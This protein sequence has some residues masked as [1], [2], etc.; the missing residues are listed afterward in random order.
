MF[1][2]IEFTKVETESTVLEF[3][4]QSEETKVN[5]FD[6]DVVSV[7]AESETDI[8]ALVN[9]QDERI[10]CKEITQDEFKSL[11]TNSA[12]LKRIREIVASEVAKRY[13]IADE[14]AMSKRAADDIKRV[15]YEAYVSQCL[16]LGYGLKAEIG[17]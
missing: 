8:V 15:E 1:K 12:Q 11:V 3:R 7:E 2:Y 13:S 4:G 9:A 5:H 17:Y 16:G 6:V 10:N 14:I